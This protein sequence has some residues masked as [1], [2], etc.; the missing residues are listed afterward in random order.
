MQNETR[1]TEELRRLAA[2]YPA[3]GD[4]VHKTIACAGMSKRSHD[5]YL[6]CVS[7]LEKIVEKLPVNEK[8]ELTEAVRTLKMSAKEETDLLQNVI[9][10][11]FDIT[12]SVNKERAFRLKPDSDGKAESKM[13]RR[14]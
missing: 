7:R 10:G 1:M 12:V 3:I 6:S 14:K 2:K 13:K 8:K 5:H 11:L 9:D 4:K